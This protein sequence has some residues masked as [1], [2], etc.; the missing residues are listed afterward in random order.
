MKKRLFV[1]MDGTLAVFKKIDELE[2]LYQKG[3]FLNLKQNEN[4]VAAVR[5]IINS[6]I[7]IEVYILSA[8][9]SD[10]KYALEEKNAWLDRYLPE[11]DHKHRIFPPCGVN[12]REYVKGGITPED[13]LLDDYTKNLREWD[14]PGSAIKLLNGINHTKGTWQG[15]KIHYTTDSQSMAKM[16]IQIMSNEIELDY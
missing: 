15:E 2:T 11:I 13:Y 5:Q 14:P 3:Y 10:S 8:Y 6:R 1:D 4:V 9:L 12:K 16:I 7:D